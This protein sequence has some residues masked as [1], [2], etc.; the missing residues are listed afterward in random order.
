ML[1]TRSLHVLSYAVL[2]VLAASASLTQGQVNSVCNNATLS[3][4]D[5][6][7]GAD[8]SCSW[9]PVLPEGI[10]TLMDQLAADGYVNYRCRGPG[11]PLICND[12]VARLDGSEENPQSETIFIE[13]RELS[14]NTSGTVITQVT[15]QNVSIKLRQ[16]ET[17][18]FN[19][20]FILL[21][22]TPLDVYF[23]SDV[24]GSLQFSIEALTAGI[25]EIA[26]SLREI[27]TGFAIGFGSFVDKKILPFGQDSNMQYTNESRTE[28]KCRIFTSDECVPSYVYHH[29][30]SLTNNVTYFQGIIANVSILS[31]S[32]DSPE[33]PLDAAVQAALCKNVIGWRDDAL[34]MMF[35]V[36]DQSY[37]FAGD[38]RIAGLYTPN[39]GKCNLAKIPGTE[40]YEYTLG[41]EEDYVSLWQIRNALEINRIIPVFVAEANLACVDDGTG[42]GMLICGDAT[43]QREPYLSLLQDL[44]ETAGIRG[45]FRV[46]DSSLQGESTITQELI[47]IIQQA[48]EATVQQVQVR[49]LNANG[50]NISITPV[51]GCNR[52]D[53]GACRVEFDA[54]VT[55]EV[56]VTL[57]NCATAQRL[58]HQFRG[59]PYEFAYID[60]EPLCKCDCT[61]NPVTDNTVCT[62]GQ[63]DLVCGVCECDDGFSGPECQCTERGSCSSNSECNGNECDVCGFCNC[64]GTAFGEF[65]Q[66]NDTVPLCENGKNPIR[67]VT[68]RCSGPERGECDCELE[69][70]ICEFAPLS[71][72]RYFGTDG[73][74]SNPDARDNNCECDPDQCYNPR[75]PDGLCVNQVNGQSSPARCGC[76]GCSCEANLLEYRST[77]VT[78]ELMCAELSTCVLCYL[79]NPCSEPPCPVVDCHDAGYIC[80]NR[81]IRQ[82]GVDEEVTALLGG[83]QGTC[84][85]DF[86]DCEVEFRFSTDI[87]V[88]IEIENSEE[89]SCPTSSVPWIIAGS[90]VGAILLLGLLAL[91]ILKICLVFLERV[92]YRKFTQELKGADFAPHENPLY[93]TP[94]QDYQNPIRRSSTRRSQ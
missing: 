40:E 57:Q 67:N 43:R 11:F 93:I 72:V 33:S 64:T 10:E 32:L 21:R 59:G 7:I 27:S 15:P 55:F 89:Y 69:R 19:M 25:I 66:C 84:Q 80:Q 68:E 30:I 52:T 2:V 75:F 54:T 91:I 85:L 73:R 50:Y 45:D 4:C 86:D 8:P 29:S 49:P 53:T 23:L 14:R 28:A 35:V 31:R 82:R 47:D 83:I 76:R 81:T 1:E 16:G 34:K 61:E 70:C 65:C 60:I 37:K 63:G 41:T 20:T 18:K 56:S 9:C 87:T 5:L 3:Q 58:R 48:Y 92:E 24:S 22:N 62:N 44:E 26:D 42:T 13:D 71:G 36:T 12:S 38:G 79:N 17:A 6:C 74:A 94:Q 88:P 51:E 39:Q 78:M 46:F 90:L 77:C